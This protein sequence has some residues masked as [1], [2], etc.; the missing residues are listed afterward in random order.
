MQR[1]PALRSLTSEHH[2]GLVIA[3]RARQA[4]REGGSAQSVAWGDVKERFQAELEGHFQR[5]ERRLLPVMRTLG[6]TAL[7]ERTLHEHKAL[8]AL[9]AE[10]RIENLGPFADLLDAHIRFEEQVL[11]DSAQRRLD[12]TL[13]A[14]LERVLEEGQQG[15]CGTDRSNG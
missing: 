1:H 7:V 3:R 6:E 9:I 4:S 8:R 14:A 11:F 5:E 15:A 12:P 13:W 10:D 2:T